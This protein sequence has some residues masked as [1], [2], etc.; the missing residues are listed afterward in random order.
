MPLLCFTINWKVLSVIVIYK[1]LMCVQR[2]TIQESKHE[3]LHDDK[4]VNI[5]QADTNKE[6]GADLEE[7]KLV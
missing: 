3:E 4:I 5:S 1:L 2:V 6:D 7:W